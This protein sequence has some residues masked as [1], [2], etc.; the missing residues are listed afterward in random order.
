MKN[1]PFDS[2]IIVSVAILLLNFAAFAQTGRNFSYQGLTYTVLDETF[3]TCETKR[4][5]QNNPAN[6]VT[7]ALTIPAQV[8]DG[9]TEFSVISIGAYS[10]SGCTKLTSV[11]L[12][13]SV[14]AIENGAFYG[15]SGLSTVSLPSSVV[16]IGNNVFRGCKSLDSVTIPNSVN[17][18][19]GSAFSDCIGLRT[20][21][22]PDSIPSIAANMFNGCES[23]ASIIIP[24][25]V[26]TI[27][28][29]AFS[30]CSSLS[31]IDFPASLT[32]IQRAAFSR[33]G[34]RTITVPSTVKSVGME[35]FSRCE[36]LESAIVDIPDIGE[37][38]FSRCTSLTSVELSDNVRLIGLNAFS[39]CSSLK[40]IRLP[41][42]LTAIRSSAFSNCVALES[43][44]LP[45]S[46]KE[47][48]GF[49]FQNCKGLRSVT[50]PDSVEIISN[51]AFN[52]CSSLDGLILPNTVKR[53]N[54]NAF[55]GCKSLSGIVIPNSVTTIEP[56]AFSECS[57]LESVSLPNSLTRLA[58]GVFSNC[59]SLK[60]VVIPSGVSVIGSQAF[61]DCN[62]LTSVELP[63]G[64]TEIEHLA[65]SGCSSLSSISF[66][67]SVKK[68]GNNAF[69]NCTSLSSVSLPDALEKIESSTFFGCGLESVVIPN[70]V[71]SIAAGAFHDCTRLSAVSF[72]NRLTSLGDRA[73]AGC[74]SLTSISLP[75][76]VT[77]IETC[78]FMDCNR[79]TTVVLPKYLPI[80]SPYVFKNCPQLS[81][82]VIPEKVNSVGAEAFYGCNNL[83]SVSF[84]SGLHNIY[85]HAFYECRS[86]KELHLPDSLVSIGEGA[87]MNCSALENLQL[88][89]NMQTINGF[90]FYGC[91]ALSSLTLPQALTSIGS[92]AFE[93]CQKLNEIKSYILEPF[94][95]NSSVF[96]TYST[97]KLYVHPTSLSRYRETVAWSNFKTILPLSDLDA[98]VLT[99]QVLDDNGNDVTDQ[100][101]IVWT[102]ENGNNLG[103]GATIS[104]Y[105]LTAPIYYSIKLDDSFGTKY[106]EI[107][108][109]SVHLVDD[110]RIVSV[111]LE[112]FGK[113]NVTGSAQCEG[114]IIS[115]LKICTRQ[116]L[117][118]KYIVEDTLVISNKDFS[119]DLVEASGYIKVES[120]GFIPVTVNFE[121]PEEVT[122]LVIQLEPTGSK[123][124]V[125]Q[126]EFIHTTSDGPQ[127]NTFSFSVNDIIYVVHEDSS[128]REICSG[129]LESCILPLP[130]D[131]KA[132][133]RLKLSVMSPGK[134]FD[135]STS[136]IAVGEPDSIPISVRLEQYGAI[137]CEA[138]NAR[139]GLFNAF[140][141]DND[142]AYLGRCSYTGNAADF[143]NLPDGHYTIISIAD[144]MPMSSLED[145]GRFGMA[146]GSHYTAS[147]ATVSKGFISRIDGIDMP[148][149]ETEPINSITANAIL[150]LSNTKITTSEYV[151]AN[152]RL[153]LSDE[154]LNDAKSGSVTFSIPEG[155]S[156]I[157]GSTLVN[158]ISTPTTVNKSNIRINLAAD[159][160]DAPVKFCL[161]ADKPG[162]YY[163]NS[164]LSLN[165]GGEITAK[166]D[167]LYLNV[168]DFYFTAP[169]RT[170]TPSFLLTG[171]AAPDS[172]L[173]IYDN[174]TMIGNA[175]S[176]KAG[177]WSTTASLI[178]PG[179][180]SSHILT[181]KGY[182][183]NG[184]RGIWNSQTV[185]YDRNWIN[186]RNITM[187]YL[188]QRVNFP[189]D[190]SA[191]DK[192]YYTYR[193][194]NNTFTFLI[195]FVRNE[196]DL[197]SNVELVVYTEKNHY[198]KLP[199]EYDANQNKWVAS[200]TFPESDLPVNVNVEYTAD[201]VYEPEFPD[202]EKMLDD[203]NATNQ[204]FAVTSG[205]INKAQQMIEDPDCPEDS[206][207]SIFYVIRREI[208]KIPDPPYLG[209]DYIEINENDVLGKE[210]SN[211][212]KNATSPEEIQ[213]IENEIEEY[214]R[215]QR[216]S[217]QYAYLMD[218]D[219]SIQPFS[220]EDDG[221]KLS[222]TPSQN[223][224][225]SVYGFEITDDNRA[226]KGYYDLYNP[227]TGERFTFDMTGI[228]DRVNTDNDPYSVIMNAI[229]AVEPF[230]SAS[231]VVLDILSERSKFYAVSNC[232]AYYRYEDCA[233]WFNEQNIKTGNTSS[234]YRR[235]YWQSRI[236]ATKALNTAKWT[237][238]VNSAVAPLAEK[239]NYLNVGITAGQAY[240]DW[241]QERAIWDK[242]ITDIESMCEG[243]TKENLLREASASRTEYNRLNGGYSVGRTFVSG[244]FCALGVISSP[245]LAG[246]IVSAAV[247]EFC[248]RSIT[249]GFNIRKNRAEGERARYRYMM[250]MSPDCKY[251]TFPG[252]SGSSGS[253]GSSSGV[254][255]LRPTPPMR[256]PSGYVYEGSPN[257]RIEGVR[258]ELYRSD[259]ES[260]TGEILWDAADY[261]QVNPQMTDVSGMYG[262][263]VP[264][265][266]Y[267]VKFAKD[268]YTT[269]SSAW[270]GVPPPQLDVNINM[271][272]L[273]AANLESATATDKDITVA[274]D[275]YM[276]AS[277]I[278]K[279]NFTIKEGGKVHECE[280]E[281][282]DPEGEGSV[283]ASRFKLI[284]SEPVESEFVTLIIG[285][286]IKTYADVALPADIECTLKINAP[287]QYVIVPEV[288]S[289]PYGDN[290]QLRVKAVPAEAVAGKQLSV[291]VLSG[292]IAGID[293]SIAAFDE[294]GYATITVSGLLPGI[295]CLVFSLEGLTYSPST[296]IV[297]D[298]EATAT[299]AAPIASIPDGMVVAQGQEV[300]LSCPTPDAIIYYTLDGTC[301]C[302]SS[303]RILYQDK[304]IILTKNTEIRALSIVEG[305]GESEIV[306]YRYKVDP[307]SGISNISSDEDVFVS[308]R[309][310]KDII[311]VSAPSYGTYTVSITNIAG[312]V[313]YHEE[314][315]EETATVNV[316]DL[317][318]GIYMMNIFNRQHNT[319][320]K[321]VKI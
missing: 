191:S 302:E 290:A 16:T 22:L 304:P 87:F 298:Q 287:I 157:I 193:S 69:S 289:V 197:I 39:Y 9:T 241:N 104:D 100:V 90:A 29:N 18:I 88:P 11:D 111:V 85:K 74:T 270:L 313:V 121:N 75:E 78:V 312:N 211:K 196:P 126:P 19:G 254:S 188:N 185:V 13:A 183:S 297:V 106:H 80:I 186:P 8:F 168:V 307:I 114:E 319:V 77:T 92:S 139:A 246:I 199:A 316:T 96:T 203:I 205:Y 253:S 261:D 41:N 251:P 86:L 259:S 118:K 131:I 1:H 187:L 190:G 160:L 23:L 113:V 235:E 300:Y 202:A 53:I 314:F 229:N 272:K 247:S 294:N 35:V 206:I 250:T 138:N 182:N 315:S 57:A 204:Q 240:D 143:I 136:T 177:I 279:S 310:A 266:Y 76:S 280:I 128:G 282:I 194:N 284:L 283:I 137:H 153:H 218:P 166:I 117:N 234:F 103:E 309:I 255:P 209:D 81:S 172:Q 181:V 263:D 94:E 150:Y 47:I 54:G 124:L 198:M 61:R 278:T 264:Q 276:D 116:Y 262:W 133:S 43:I 38:M 184:E 217:T 102:D 115:E 2:R 301:P 169:E 200:Y 56:N 17:D 171:T 214:L 207:E 233:K 178:E 299:V 173:E 308:P 148:E 317:T 162:N 83:S 249:H 216:E 292:M 201:T 135:E 119:I 243:S 50:I 163:I 30:G 28:S 273:A 226:S 242:L 33:S 296:K 158:G 51:G 7:G 91:K 108:K 6:N 252:G 82:I 305:V 152:L 64:I 73:F 66:P 112:P 175:V 170:A 295:D 303:S 12:P 258:A 210:L 189:M 149:D 5:S 24:Q 37:N 71:V 40:S 238:Q 311:N 230:C 219:S 225:I 320:V 176:N 68:I 25:S 55:H 227:T 267:Q 151:T 44:A 154:I 14:T 223:G 180:L 257:K 127:N 72:G 248:D 101:T 60:T 231:S 110:S 159:Q 212:I 288:F 291:S 130:R 215:Q 146:A 195:D 164:I 147:E 145:Y 123:C 84:P 122:P 3:R 192:K 228:I 52:G 26:K 208:D 232:E 239:L 144:D 268:G 260:R 59:T 99:I 174:Q 48:S 245:T 4:G 167:G 45:P 105:D 165:Y 274:M 306:V 285:K 89:D 293:S 265:G 318:A 237:A 286:G 221:V 213:T 142:G 62:G 271:R 244:C 10:F 155:C 31:K 275:T 125:L 224:T 49:V 141:Y 277:T 179:N 27:N 222:Y 281:L 36:N 63:E 65:F 321:I 32:S 93:A 161:R 129:S 97:A 98:D 220:G 236:K 21:S 95:I 134:V 46:L 107:H 120:K 42:Y 79:L 269:A 156:Y 58:N 109:A 15:C 256:D 34:L 67:S 70:S 132:G 20:I 140:L